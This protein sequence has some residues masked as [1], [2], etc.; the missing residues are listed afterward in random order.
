MNGLILNVSLPVALF[1]SIK[2]FNRLARSTI[3]STS[4]NSSNGNPIIKYN[5][6]FLIPAS[7]PSLTVLKICSSSIPLLMT[8]LI[9]ALPASGAIVKVLR[10]LATRASTSSAVTESARNDATDIGNSASR[11]I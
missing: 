9:L 2:S 4:D 3:A 7:M 11:I 8:A 6:K 1:A 10:P 5:L